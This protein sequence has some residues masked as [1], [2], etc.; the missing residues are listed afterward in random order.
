MADARDSKSRDGNIMPVQVRPSAPL[1][2]VC[3]KHSENQFCIFCSIIQ[4]TIPS[5]IITQNNECIVIQ[6]IAPKAPVHY[7]IIPKK[8]I[9]DLYNVEESDNSF[10]TALFLMAQS[11]GLTFENNYPFRLV[12]N[13][14]KDAGQSVFHLHLHFLA[15]NFI[16]TM[17]S[18]DI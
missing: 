8:H 5:T 16:P 15:G 2:M 18:K 9:S 1:L 17:T 6:D 3:M 13:N 7:L 14:G 11:I 4:G 12:L 10:I